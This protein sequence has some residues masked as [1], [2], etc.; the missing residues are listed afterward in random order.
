MRLRNGGQ[1]MNARVMG[2]AFVA[3]WQI[4]WQAHCDDLVVDFESVQVRKDTTDRLLSWPVRPAKSGNALRAEVLQDDVAW[5][6]DA[7]MGKGAD[8]AGGWRAEAVGP[9]ENQSNHSVRYE[10]STLLD[11]S[12]AVDPRLADGT[13]TWQ[14]IF[15]WH[16]GDKDQGGSPPVAFIIAGDHIYLDVHTVKSGASVQVGQWPLA[17]LD[18]G[19]WHDFAAE[20]KWHRTDG[21]IKLWHNGQAVTFA[22][23]ASP[24]SPGTMFPS[25]ATDTLANLTTLFPPKAGSSR[26][27]SVYLKVG[28]Y[29]RA[30]NTT[31]SQTFVVYHDEICRYEWAP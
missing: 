17:T 2:D 24:A 15:Q 8:I 12:Y 9:T 23:V 26:P 22:P 18:R 29:R 11:P 10:W 1:R 13:R 19:T 20:I 25:S 16:Q 31:P 5:N 6:P 30:A 7:N 21:T 28:L 27:S 14:V 4:K 3:G